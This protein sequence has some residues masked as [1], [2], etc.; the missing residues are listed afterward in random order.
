MR[1]TIDIENDVLHAIKELAGQQ[2]VS[3]GKVVS[4]LLRAAL[5]GK[6]LEKGK[7]PASESITGFHPFTTHEVSIVTNEQINQIRDG[8]GI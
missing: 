5:S 6:N 1:T 7:S 2:H 4:Q 8:E 3:A